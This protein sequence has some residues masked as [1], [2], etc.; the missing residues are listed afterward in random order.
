MKRFFVI[1]SFVIVAVSFATCKIDR[2]N[3]LIGE[4]KQVSFDNPEYSDTIYWTFYAGDILEIRTYKGKTKPKK[5]VVDTTK[6][7]PPTPID[8]TSNAD[9]TAIAKMYNR[10]YRLYADS[11]VVDSVA[12]DSVQVDTTPKPNVQPTRPSESNG[13]LKVY[14]YTTEGKDL[15]IFGEF[16]D[17]DYIIGSADIRGK[18]WMDEIKKGKRLKI[19]RRKHPDGSEGG[20]FLRIELVKM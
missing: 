11:M 17:D 7:T 19:A 10:G 1:I 5:E 16:G 2:Q 6:V 20:A 9:T 14:T 13:V 3:K 8:T 4:W 12:V 18:Y 15:N